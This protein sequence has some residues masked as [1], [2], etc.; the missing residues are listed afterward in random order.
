MI[1]NLSIGVAERVCNL[2]IGGVFYFVFK[3]IHAHY[4]IFTIQPAWYYWVLLLLLT[5]LVWYWYH[6]LGH[7]INI[8]WAFHI[9]HHQSEDF[10]YTTST[11]ITIFQAL[12]RNVFWCVLPLLGFPADMVIIILVVHGAY[13]FFTH[14]ELI[15]KLGWIEKVLITPSHHR[16]HHASNA[17]YLDKNYGDVFVFWDKLFGTFKEEEH[18]PVYGITKPL[19][20]HS[21]L[22]QHF[23]YLIEITYRV[24][25]TQGL[26]NKLKVI[27]GRPDTMAGDEREIVEAIWLNQ[28]EPIPLIERRTGRYKRYINIQFA[29]L[30]LGLLLLILY[31]DRFS[32]STDFFI[33]SV[34]ILTLINCCALLEQKKWIFFV[35][36]IRI[37]AILEFIALQYND[38]PQFLLCN[39]GVLVFTMLYNT[40]RKLYLKLVY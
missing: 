6:R 30:L 10:N 17:E 33:S 13:S 29:G 18:K 23:H 22:W 2:W 31:F 36:Y 28:V 34:M 38:S 3:Y 40:L 5:D 32:V 39:A 11:R 9:V 16:V 26:I 19:K 12:V 37:L 20:T 27:F 1:S 4:A 14:T 25:Q 35:E 7:E 15:G 8:L 24:R 21:F